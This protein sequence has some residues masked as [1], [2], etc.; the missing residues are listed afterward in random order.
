M[1]LCGLDEADWV[2]SGLLYSLT[3]AK[4][5]MEDHQ[6]APCFA[7]ITENLC[8]CCC[9]EE[10]VRR[11]RVQTAEEVAARIRRR[12]ADANR[13]LVA[14]PSQRMSQVLGRKFQTG[15]QLALYQAALPRD[16]RLAC[17][18]QTRTATT[19]VERMATA[20]DESLLF[21]LLSVIPVS[22]RLELLADITHA[23]TQAH[24]WNTTVKLL[25]GNDST[26]LVRFAALVHLSLVQSL[27]A[28]MVCHPAVEASLGPPDGSAE[29]EVAAS[30]CLGALHAVHR[31]LRWK[32]M[33][34]W[35]LAMAVLAAAVVT[36]VVASYFLSLFSWFDIKDKG[37]GFVEILIFT[38]AVA[39]VLIAILV[40]SINICCDKPRVLASLRHHTMRS[41]VDHIPEAYQHRSY[42]YPSTESGEWMQG[43][44]HNEQGSLPYYPLHENHILFMK[45][46]EQAHAAAIQAHAYDGHRAAEASFGREE[47]NASL[48]LNVYVN[49]Q[50]IQ[51]EVRR[52][53]TVSY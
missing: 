21:G 45:H 38:S 20:G 36:F 39:V 7:C 53:G 19:Q 28:G 4:Y 35:A 31:E 3:D 30:A 10:S 22:R 32:S 24:G 2:E 44:L 51:I 6:W 14:A 43:W 25:Y 42:N 13:L 40:G 29:Q 37:W 49:G 15:T 8:S 27:K 33:P 12:E 16:T 11:R 1:L 23:P 52:G 18:R 34:Y 26:T 47:M 46:S 50:S 48:F 9:S 41:Y 17:V 5:L